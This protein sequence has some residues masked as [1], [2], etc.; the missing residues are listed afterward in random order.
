M[1]AEALDAEPYTDPE[2][3][4]QLRLQAFKNER[5][6]VA[7][8]DVTFS[9]QKSVTVLHAAF[10]YQEVQARRA[11]DEEAAAAWAAHKQAVEAAIWAGHR[12]AMDYLAEH[13]GYSRVGHHGGGA[14]RFTDAHGLIVASF[15]QH[16]SRENDPHLHIHGAVLNRVQG[17]DGVWRTLD[18]R[19]LTVHRPAA[20]A[21][22]ERTTTEHVARSLRVL[23]VMRPDGKAREIFDVPEA[24]NRLLSARDRAITP[25]TAERVALFEQRYGR[26]PNALERDRLH[27]KAWAITRPRKS[28]DGET[29]EQ[30]LDRVAAQLRAELNLS[31]E[32]IAGRVLAKAGEDLAAQKLD[33]DA[34]IETA[35]ADVQGTKASWTEADLATAVND[36]L[37][38]Y[39]GGL[40]SADISDL[41]RGLTRQ[42]IDQHCVDL[43]PDGPAA[44]SLPNEL[45]LADGSSV[46]QRPGERRF[47]TAEHVRSERALRAA[48]IER[49]A[50]RITPEVAGAFLTELRESGI[51]LGVDQA[52][53]VRGVLTSGAGME[54]LI[55]PAGTGKSFVLGAI[56]R[57]WQDPTLWNSHPHR[58]VG[59]ATSQIAAQ[60]LHG[61]GL[62]ARNIAQ[63]RAVQQRLADGR[64]FGDDT[65]WQLNPGDLVVVD[66]SAMTDHADLAAVHD[67]V[68]AADAKPL[69]TGDHRQLAAVGAAGGMDMIARVSPAY[70]LTEARRFTNAWERDASLKLREG[71]KTALQD[72]RK[73]GR[74]IDGGPLER[75]EHLAAEAWLADYLAGKRGLLIVAPT[76]KPPR[77]APRSAP[78]W[79]G[80]A[81]SRNTACRSD[82]TTPRPASGTSCKPV[83]TAGNC[84]ASTGTAA[85]RSTASITG[86]SRPAPTA[87]C[88]SPR[89]WP[90]PRTG[91]SSA[92]ASPSRPGT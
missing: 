23:A 69:L 16:T 13:A 87:G 86:S 59:L 55:G 73:H 6:N 7:F 30:R 14:G 40:D 31:F 32:T 11:G 15:F 28:H 19:S 3:R 48:A 20:A 54:S 50:A 8:Y 61:E 85:A 62:R 78:A 89:S 41:I 21:V 2:R 88:S 25:K 53:A 29:L 75:T 82:C 80:S 44:E 39:L 92:N 26:V 36:A 63:W 43:T 37:P 46:Y 38:D 71:D 58:V 18:G 4:E 83:A 45:R 49:T 27:R 74:I 91:N 66:E 1:Y 22:G 57:A 76:N 72:Y 47:A 33:P 65:D 17:A 77:S 84:A 5:H 52:A 68:Q 64:A 70:E 67:I 24:A 34:V 81:T 9:V 56:A 10:E 51:E 79:S 12:A 42:A 60:V 90:A 35:L